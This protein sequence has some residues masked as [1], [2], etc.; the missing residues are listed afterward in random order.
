MID[1]KAMS[2][3]HLLALHAAIMNELRDRGVVRSANNPTD[4]LAEFLFCRAF[5]WQQT[6]N[7]AKG[8]DA[9]DDSGKRYQIKGRRLH[10]RNKSRQ[11]SAIRD[12]D[13]FDMLAAVLFDDEYRV[14]RAALIPCGIVRERSNFVP[15]TNSYAFILTDDVWDDTRVTDVTA[16]LRAAETDLDN[17]G[18]YPVDNGETPSMPSGEAGSGII[19]ENGPTS[20]GD[21]VEDRQRAEDE[22]STDAAENTGP[23]TSSTA[24]AIAPLSLNET[25]VLDWA[26][27]RGFFEEHGCVVS[28]SPEIRWYRGSWDALMQSGLANATPS[29][30]H[31]HARTALKLRAI[32]LLAMYLGIYQAAGEF[33]ELGGYF[34]EHSSISDYLDSLNMEYEE[35]WELARQVGLFDTDSSSYWEDEEADDEWLCE[36]AMD[37][38]RDEIGP[39]YSALKEHYGGDKGLFVSLWNSRVPLHE[40]EPVQ[41]VVNAVDAGDGKLEVWSYVQ[42]GMTG[43]WWT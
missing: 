17:F 30:E 38:V 23:E 4:D 7:S 5:F 13:G 39:I 2:R 25:E 36:I 22:P 6:P 10:C 31:G 43:W 3:N 12:L 24:P 33:S 29:E 20:R 8:F 42:E 34:S 26:D 9:T 28:G 1:L 27:V 40:I 15:H 11:L 14:F 21:A 19:G 37:L 35:V 18:I 41:D 32:C 16:E